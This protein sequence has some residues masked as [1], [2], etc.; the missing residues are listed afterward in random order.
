[1]LDLNVILT[2]FPLKRGKAVAIMYGANTPILRNVI[3]EQLKFEEAEALGAYPRAG[4]EFNEFLPSER[5]EHESKMAVAL[6]ASQILKAKQ[7]LELHAKLDEVIELMQGN[8]TDMGVTLFMPHVIDFVLKKTADIVRRLNMTARAR[9]M[10]EITHEMLEV[11]NYQLENPIDDDVMDYLQGKGL[12]CV[13]WTVDPSAKAEEVLATFM[14]KATEPQLVPVESENGEL[15]LVEQTALEPLIVYLDGDDKSTAEP[16]ED[17]FDLMSKTSDAKS[18]T[19]EDGAGGEVDEQL[20]IEAY[21]EEK[22][23]EAQRPML[24]IPPAWTPINQAGNA[25]FKYTFFRHVRNRGM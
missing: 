20:E 7:D 6:A 4:F 8:S 21:Q 5:F 10:I 1:M 18:T 9:K 19:S 17:I 25:V 14:R 16:S 22:L 12:L 3:A 13:L 2:V 11:L 23:E 24:I 15:I